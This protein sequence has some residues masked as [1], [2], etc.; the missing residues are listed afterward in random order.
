MNILNTF[1]HSRLFLGSIAA[2]AVSLPCFA[3][4]AAVLYETHGAGFNVGIINKI[5]ST[6]VVTPFVTGLNYPSA[7]AFDASGNLYEADSGTGKINKISSAGVVTPFVITTGISSLSPLAFDASG[8]LYYVDGTSTINKI[9]STGVVTPFVT[10]LF[11]TALAFDASGNLYEADPGT[12]KINKIS[13]AGVVTPF[14]ITTGIS[15]PAK[16]LAFDASGNL[17]GGGFD[18]IS[19]I[20]LTGVVTPFITGLQPFAL[21]FDDATG[22]LFEV[23]SDGRINKISSTGVVTP[24]AAVS[25]DNSYFKFALAFGPDT[26][27]TPPSTA[28]PEP[29][30]VIGTLIGGTAALRLRR[31]L[32]S[33]KKV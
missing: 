31:K 19:K 24:F 25:A 30:T 16:S 9:S 28:V 32:K 15:Y 27:P 3:A 14:V 23:E 13:S 11:P 33:T 20:S 2:S 26:I 12:R 29:F 22:N 7:L 4:S 17:Y 8:N 6:G 5:S 21:A 10:G 1:R 18:G